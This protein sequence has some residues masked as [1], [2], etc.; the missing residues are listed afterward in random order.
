MKVREE[1]LRRGNHE[2]TCRIR[3]MCEPSMVCRILIM[4]SDLLSAH[5]TSFRSGEAGAIYRAVPGWKILYWGAGSYPILLRS[6]RG[7]RCLFSYL[8]PPRI[9]E[10]SRGPT[11]FVMATSLL[12]RERSMNGITFP[13][14]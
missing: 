5:S 12:L 10:H 14:L 1:T 6:N 11:G 9:P 8:I 4:A 3:A 7:R 13:V 2:T